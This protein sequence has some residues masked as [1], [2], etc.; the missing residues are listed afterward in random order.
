MSKWA[1]SVILLLSSLSGFCGDKCPDVI[2]DMQHFQKGLVGIRCH[3]YSCTEVGIGMTY[4][5]V[6]GQ[7]GRRGVEGTNCE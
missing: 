1:A 7:H 3:F 5:S 4:Q 6:C 2:M